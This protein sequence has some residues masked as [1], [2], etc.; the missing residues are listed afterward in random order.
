M[1]CFSSRSRAGKRVP[2]PLPVN[3][4][5]VK[6]LNAFLPWSL[7]HS[8]LLPFSRF[9][10]GRLSEI[11]P[12]DLSGR[13]PPWTAELERWYHQFHPKTWDML[14]EDDDEDWKALAAVYDRLAALMA[15]TSPSQAVDDECHEQER[16]L[17][18]LEIRIVMR[19]YRLLALHKVRALYFEMQCRTMTH[20]E[21]VQALPE[22]LRIKA[23]HPKAGSGQ[24]WPLPVLPPHPFFKPPTLFLHRLPLFN[25]I[26]PFSSVTYV[27]PS[28]CVLPDVETLESK[29]AI[30]PLEQ[31]K[32]VVTIP[33]SSIVRFQQVQ[34]SAAMSST[35]PPKSSTAPT[36]PSTGSATLPVVSA[37]TDTSDHLSASMEQA[38]G[39]SVCD[40]AEPDTG[41]TVSRLETGQPTLT[42][43]FDGFFTTLPGA[44]GDPQRISSST[45]DAEKSL[46]D[47]EKEKP[48]TSVSGSTVA[49][50]T[51]MG[52]V[53]RLLA[54]LLPQRRVADGY[55]AI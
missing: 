32:F 42:T 6:Q 12:Q 33:F 25:G 31:K 19:W 14:E 2:S 35:G 41:T 4:V 47:T 13:L 15:D 49:Q 37:T 38:P 43:Q 36:R 34:P 40:L 54:N 48:E 21:A 44:S 30:Q 27:D 45:E 5:P 22:G 17:Q 20:E 39:E 1:P 3:F 53:G 51:F 46:Y 16:R 11:V 52:Q 23:L 29:A 50:P 7:H 26:V 24:V 18:C 10:A 28:A 8:T 55:R 9:D